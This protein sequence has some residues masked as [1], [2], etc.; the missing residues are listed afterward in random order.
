M[1]TRAAQIHLAGHMRLAGHVFETP[2][3]EEGGPG[4]NLIDR[5]GLCVKKES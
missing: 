1:L 5:P 4:D 2:D 3:L